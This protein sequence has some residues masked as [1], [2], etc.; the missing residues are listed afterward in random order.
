MVLG[1]FFL[2]R[3]IHL[4]RGLNSIRI[5][6]WSLTLFSVDLGNNIGQALQKH[7]L[8]SAFVMEQKKNGV[9][10]WSLFTVKHFGLMQDSSRE[11]SSHPTFRRDEKI[12]DEILK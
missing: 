4:A 1:L 9:W 7:M 12:N 3:V 11:E 6:Y 10:H 8:A 5:D 2:S